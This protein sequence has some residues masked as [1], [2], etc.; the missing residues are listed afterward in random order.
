MCMDV[1][2]ACMY[3][4]HVVPVKAR[5]HQMLWNWS[6]RWLLIAMCMLGNEAIPLHKL[7]S[8]HSMTQGFS[9]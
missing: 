1:L 6:Y 8:H 7:V 2:P 9:V 3:H 4:V 5:R